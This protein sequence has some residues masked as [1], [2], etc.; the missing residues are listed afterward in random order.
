MAE[1]M[2]PACLEA[3][4]KNDTMSNAPPPGYRR[5]V[6]GETIEMAR[7][8]WRVRLSDGHAAE[9]AT[10]WSEDGMMAVVADQ[11]LP[12]ISANLGTDP[13]EPDGDTINNSMDAVS[14]LGRFADD[15]R[16]ALPG[17]ERPYRGLGFRLRQIATNHGAVL[18]RLRARLADGPI[19]AC[20]V[21][22]LVHSTAA[23]PVDIA[24]AAAEMHAYLLHLSKR[25]E[26]TWLLDAQG[27]AVFRAGTHHPRK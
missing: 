4:A 11:A 10:F 7:R 15:R 18:G 24:F 23:E 3:G 19:R 12:S 14:R 13:R 2:I 22:S 8:T 26:A 9:H 6:E 27:V 25:G 20:D 17:H 16:L 5:L 21:V 1:D